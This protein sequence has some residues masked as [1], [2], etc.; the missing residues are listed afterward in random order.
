MISHSVCLRISLTNLKEKKILL[1][2]MRLKVQ[3]C[4]T[5]LNFILK[6]ISM[7]S[8][9]GSQ[10]STSLTRRTINT[11]TPPIVSSSTPRRSTTQSSTLCKRCRILSPPYLNVATVKVTQR[12]KQVVRASSTRLIMCSVNH[13]AV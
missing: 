9:G 11:S 8:W 13:V 10:T 2:K 1:L 6:E 5:T 4:L 7:G 3:G 12:L